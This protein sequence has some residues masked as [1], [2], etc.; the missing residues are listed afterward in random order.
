ML[1]DDESNSVWFHANAFPRSL[2][3][4]I[5]LP[6]LIA[7]AIANAKRTF[8]IWWC[9]VH[10]FVS[11]CVCC[12]SMISPRCDEC[13]HKV[14]FVIAISYIVFLKIDIG[15]LSARLTWSVCFELAFA[16]IVRTY[17]RM[18]TVD[19]NAGYSWKLEFLTV[20]FIHMC[21]CVLVAC[22]C[23]HICSR[24]TAILFGL[25]EFHCTTAR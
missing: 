2:F 1:Y 13:W 16:S 15:K 21:M 22:A 18:R 3:L 12:V 9:C 23:V 25:N 4:L 24:R 14:S 7:I 19:W 8:L 5:F 17:E 6:P 10:L 11:V 20:R